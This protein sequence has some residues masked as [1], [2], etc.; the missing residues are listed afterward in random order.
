MVNNPKPLKLVDLILSLHVGSSF[1]DERLEP[2]GSVCNDLQPECGP[3]VKHWSEGQAA[4]R[5]GNE[6]GLEGA[7]RGGKTQKQQL[8]R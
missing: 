1:V 3:G 4:G 6:S 8:R 5:V 2:R 7:S